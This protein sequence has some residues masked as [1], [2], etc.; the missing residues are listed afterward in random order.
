M[1]IFATQWSKVKF[2]LFFSNLLQKKNNDPTFHIDGVLVFAGPPCNVYSQAQV[3][4]IKRIEKDIE[5]YK[6]RLFS[7]DR[8][9]LA[10][11]H[12]YSTL[13]ALLATQNQEKGFLPV[14][15]IL[16][17]PFGREVF[18]LKTPKTE[19]LLPWALRACFFFPT[20]FCRKWWNDFQS[21]NI[22]VFTRKFEKST[23]K[24]ND[25]HNFRKF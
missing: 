12:I 14:D 1:V 10:T 4:N 3:G 13:Q 20:F 9:V 7:S 21:R 17:N 25:F 24:N 11:L 15:L 2:L 23:K 5:L 22:F 16:E 8:M 6:Q 18:R 19:I